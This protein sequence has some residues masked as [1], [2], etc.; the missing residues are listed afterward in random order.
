MP[1]GISLDR[2]AD[3]LDKRTDTIP[4]VIGFVGRVVPIK[5]TYCEDSPEGQFLRA[6]AKRAYDEVFNVVVTPATPDGLHK[7]HLHFDMA[8]YT[9]D[10]S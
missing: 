4:P 10:G 5:D 3:A 1:N 6:M 8:H 9:F 2:Y 7:M